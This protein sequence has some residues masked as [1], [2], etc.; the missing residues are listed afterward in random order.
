MALVVGNVRVSE[1]KETIKQG[2][3][4]RMILNRLRS[5]IHITVIPPWH[6]HSNV[7]STLRLAWRNIGHC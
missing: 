5:S 2:T 1:G 3:V 4:G 6:L 7:T